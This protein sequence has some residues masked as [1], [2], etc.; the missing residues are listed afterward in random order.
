MDEILI[1]IHLTKAQ[2]E[3]LAT[4]Q[5]VETIV[6]D[7]PWKLRCRISARYCQGKRAYDKKGAQTAKNKRWKEDHVKLRVYQCELEDHWHLT[8]SL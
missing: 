6:T 3:K 2:I 8:S 4:G 5:A 1:E 7:A